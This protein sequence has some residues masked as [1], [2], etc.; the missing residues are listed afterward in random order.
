M[1][2]LGST[3]TAEWM[4]LLHPIR[5]VLCR[6]HPPHCSLLTIRSCCASDALV[7]NYV[8]KP[9]T[10]SHVGQVV[11]TTMVVGNAGCMLI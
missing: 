3:L 9:L 11:K 1:H 6:L 2:A 4:H 10:W 5:Q 7:I 8:I